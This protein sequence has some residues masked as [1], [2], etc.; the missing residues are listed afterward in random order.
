MNNRR[1]LVIALGAGAL[2]A[3]FGSFAQ[4][5]RK[6][7]RIGFLS[8]SAGIQFREE[9]LR[10]G[11]R[12]LGYV[13]GKNLFIEWRFTNGNAELYS[14]F[15][16][17]LVVL[18]PDCIV[19]SGVTATRAAKQATTVIPVVMANADGDPVREG[20]AASLAKPG[21]N[22]TGLISISANL[23]GKRLELIRET[24]PRVSRVAVLWDPNSKGAEDVISEARTAAPKL[25]IQL[26]FIEV[27][28]T[29][30]LEKAFRTATNARANA[31]MQVGGG[32]INSSNLITQSIISLAKKT[33]LP[34]MYPNSSYVIAGGLMSYAV[35][36]DDQFHR[37]A[38]Y[39]D[40]ILKGAK[41]ADLPIEQPTKFELVLNLKTAKA[42]GIKIPN[43]VLVQATKV[44]E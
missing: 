10:R 3:P 12:E 2:A 18:K 27:R 13:E 20:F 22:I 7:W 26:I 5:Q 21:G 25:G 33:R 42:L 24:L 36:Y 28:G 11:L 41:P 6:V 23:A 38:G 29:E 14:K 34:V 37:A 31:V 43:S 1:K 4:Q 40:K 39:V 8:S 30:T 9:A 44:I 32:A 17:E 35:N 19:V 15:A 16:A